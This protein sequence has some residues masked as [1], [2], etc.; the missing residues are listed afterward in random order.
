MA[1]ALEMRASQC[2]VYSMGERMGV[3]EQSAEA[4]ARRRCERC[5]GVE[6]FMCRRQTRRR[7]DAA[8]FVSGAKLKSAAHA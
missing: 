2:G 4:H 3:S 5:E 7:G 1:F 6:A 8:A